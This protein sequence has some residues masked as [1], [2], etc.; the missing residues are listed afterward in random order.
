MSWYFSSLISVRTDC[1]FARSGPLKRRHGAGA[2]FLQISIVHLEAGCLEET[3]GESAVIG[4]GESGIVQLLNHIP[5]STC[6]SCLVDEQTTLRTSS[7]RFVTK[8]RTT[9]S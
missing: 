6:H 8:G 1:G 2:E 9:Q 3:L 7:V 5:Q 4:N